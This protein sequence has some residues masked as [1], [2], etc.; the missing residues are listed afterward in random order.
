MIKSKCTQ[1][2]QKGQLHIVWL[3]LA[4]DWVGKDRSIVTAAVTQKLCII[5]HYPISI[6]NMLTTR[7]LTIERQAE[8][9]KPPITAYT[10]E[11]VV[12]HHPYIPCTFAHNIQER[13]LGL[14]IAE[15][16]EAPVFLNK[17]GSELWGLA[18]FVSH[19]LLNVLQQKKQHE[20]C[21]KGWPNLLILLKF[22]LAKLLHKIDMKW[23]PQDKRPKKGNPAPWT[24]LSLFSDQEHYNTRSSTSS[25][26]PMSSAWLRRDEV[27]GAGKKRLGVLFGTPRRKNIR[28]FW[29]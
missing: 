26:S 12:H 24:V 11:T 3:L 9:L 23:Y 22:I 28:P 13:H 21:Y 29:W 25:P 14:E 1:K 4:T 18:R 17:N 8:S 2:T 15:V 20:V 27:R 6:E 19:P 7:R 10:S 5:I 16:L